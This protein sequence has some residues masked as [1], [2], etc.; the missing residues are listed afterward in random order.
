MPTRKTSERI[1]SVGDTLDFASDLTVRYLSERADLSTA[2]A[3]LLNRLNREGPSRLTVLAAREGVSQ[4][5]MTQLVQRLERQGLVVRHADPEDGRVALVALSAE[6]T[7]LL[8][9]RKVTRRDRLAEL[10]GTLTPEESRAL[11]LAAEVA[12]PILKGLIERAD[13]CAQG[14]AGS[15]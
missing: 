3:F 5:S 7:A 14:E 4:P 9:D 1:H 13:A 8:E 6:G 15:D 2:A 12:L 11:W 10:L